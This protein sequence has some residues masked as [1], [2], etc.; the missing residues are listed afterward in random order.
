MTPDIKS[1]LSPIVLPLI[2]SDSA[3]QPP[4][5]E[6]AQYRSWKAIFDFLGAAFATPRH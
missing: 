3:V 2:R 1:P 6:E 5:F 4:A